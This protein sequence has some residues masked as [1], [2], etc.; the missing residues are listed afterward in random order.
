MSATPFKPSNHITVLSNDS[1]TDFDRCKSNHPSNPVVRWVLIAGKVFAITPQT[2]Y[3]HVLSNGKDYYP[4][5][6][7]DLTTVAHD[8]LFLY[9][10]GDNYDLYCD[11]L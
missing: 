10:P 8:D 4:Y 7:H 2:C 5:Y 1:T 11:S 6:D 3:R 9:P